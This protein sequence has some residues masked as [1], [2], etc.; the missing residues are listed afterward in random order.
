[1]QEKDKLINRLNIYSRGRTLPQ[2]KHSAISSSTPNNL[3]LFDNESVVTRL[4]KKLKDLEL[5]RNSVV[6]DKVESSPAMSEQS[7]ARVASSRARSSSENRT[8]RTGRQLT[9]NQK[10]FKHHKDSVNLSLVKRL[11]S[12]R[13]STRLNSSHSQ[14]SRMPSSA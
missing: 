10:G 2:L 4:D 11:G 5:K 9:S 12:D 3:N 6:L 7:K 14:Q 8:S 13:K 1:M